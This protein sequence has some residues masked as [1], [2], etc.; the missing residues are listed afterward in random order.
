MNY[1]PFQQPMNYPNPL[2]QLAQL[3]QQAMQPQYPPQ[4]QQPQ[5]Q[6]GMMWVRNRAEAENYPLPP[7]TAIALWDASGAF[8]H[9]KETDVSGKPMITTFKLVEVSDIPQNEPEF[10]TWDKFTAL[11]ENVS[12]LANHIKSMNKEGNANE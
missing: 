8:V 6:T 11:A 7:N 9:R 10:V 4:M 5:Q 1:Y 3:R 12:A 2:D